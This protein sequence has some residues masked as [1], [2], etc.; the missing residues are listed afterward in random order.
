[1][2]KVCALAP[3]TTIS[4]FL[5][6]SRLSISS[7]KPA[8]SPS[9]WSGSNSAGFVSVRKPKHYEIFAT[10]PRVFHLLFI[11]YQNSTPQRSAVL[12]LFINS[13]L[14]LEYVQAFRL[15]LSETTRSLALSS[16]ALPL[17]IGLYSLL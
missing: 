1:M 5:A 17:A 2:T 9:R 8:N 3:P 11:Q 16:L 13:Y 6:C 7:H 14:I 4:M 10:V 15:G 12:N